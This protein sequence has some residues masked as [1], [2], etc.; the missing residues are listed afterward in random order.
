MDEANEIPQE[1]KE[2]EEFHEAATIVSPR[3]TPEDA[4]KE[5]PVDE[6]PEE[7]V[8]EEPPTA[9]EPF[10]PGGVDI[11]V[12]DPPKNN[13]KKIIIIVV[14]VLLLLCCCCV[15]LPGGGVLA[16]PDAIE[17]LLWEMGI[18]L[19]IIGGFLA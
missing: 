13:K 7:T 6:T 15:V 18:G 5:D 10:D 16:F 4:L 2:D 8:I 12:G 11:P 3:V 9:E 17:D 14:V 19:R 1:E